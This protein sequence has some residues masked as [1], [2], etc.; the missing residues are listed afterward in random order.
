[1][2]QTSNSFYEPSGPA[3][4]LPPEPSQARI[5]SILAIDDDPNVLSIVSYK[6]QDAGYEVRTAASG[7]QGLDIIAQRGLPHLAIVDINMPGMNGFEFCQTVQQST[8]LPI[9]LLTAVDDEESIIRGIE[10]YAEDYIVKPFSPRELLARMQRV[11]RRI[12]D[13]GYTL[14]PQVRVDEYLSVN[15]VQQR[16]T[17][18][19]VGIALTPIENK[20][21]YILMRNAGQTVT[22]EFLLRRLWPLDTV[23]E[24][25]L[26][27]HVSNLRKKIEPEP[28]QPR[29][30]ITMR[31]TGYKF[32][33][34]R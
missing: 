27:V 17:I 19:G 22:T 2:S 33:A 8:D 26:R 1:M 6:L 9:I 18:S 21:L 16:A 7:R 15:L 11:L 13:F 14:A 30:I 24:D 31:G 10:Q 32:P 20:L 28:S 29:Y 4:A 34:R 12:G 25:T 3:G 5:Q 23:Y